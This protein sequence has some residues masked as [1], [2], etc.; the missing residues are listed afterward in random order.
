[1]EVPF[2]VSFI[3]ALLFAIHPMRV[4][5]VVW[6]TERKDVLFGAFYLLSLIFYIQ[7]I[8]QKKAWY[9]VLALLVFILSLLSKIQA[10][11]LPLSLLLVDYWF[12]RKLSK[13]LVLEKIPFFVL[14]LAT[15]LVGIY[16]LRQQGSLDTTS[17]FPLHQ[18]LFIGS[19]SF[20]VYLLKSVFPWEMS[21]VYPYPAN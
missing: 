17:L 1:M 19:Y 16:F 9:Y 20:I 12:S 10:V 18:R 14:S 13:K 4:E 2:W 7:Y 11:A 8:R 5:S 21:A 15:G 6:I 3:T